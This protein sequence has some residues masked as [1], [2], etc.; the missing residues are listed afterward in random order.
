MDADFLCFE[1]KNFTREVELHNRNA[2]KV[3]DINK[4]RR[5]VEFE[6]EMQWMQL[7]FSQ[8]TCSQITKRHMT[9]Q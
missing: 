7:D 5:S 6:I 3:F 1:S 9:V 8:V 4:C 2:G